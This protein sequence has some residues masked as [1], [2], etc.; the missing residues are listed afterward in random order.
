M[1][2]KALSITDRLAALEDDTGVIK[3]ALGQIEAVA[4]DFRQS[5][6]ENVTIKNS[7]DTLRTRCNNIL[8]MGPSIDS[9]ITL[10]SDLAEAMGYITEKQQDGSYILKKKPSKKADKKKK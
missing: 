1:A 4:R 2:E 5:K 10:I 9:A 7:I 8:A 3:S 6:L